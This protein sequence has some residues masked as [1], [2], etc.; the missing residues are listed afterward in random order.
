VNYPTALLGISDFPDTDSSVSAC[1]AYN[2][3]FSATYQ[4]A[5]HDRLLA[6]ALV[7]LTNVEAAVGEATRAVNELGAVGIM[8]QPYADGAHLCD[9]QYDA[10]W[11]VVQS[12]DVPVGIH[13]SRHTCPPH[14]RGESFRSQSRFYA[15]SHPFQ[16]QV[17]MG[18]LVLGGVFDRFPNLKVVFLESGVGWMPHYIDRLDEAYRSVDEDGARVELA[19]KPSDYLLSGNCWFSCESDEPNLSATVDF[20]GDSQVIY[21]S[22]YPHFD[23]SF[24]DSVKDLIEESGL[25]TARI[26]KIAGANSRALYKL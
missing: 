10:L 11:R 14:L 3:W 22:D 23:C 17:A 18:D 5:A 1:H 4:K 15:M 21:A 24:P 25:T 16:Q 2:D 13:G 8:V 12:L 6:M 20:L 7:P 9:P 26:E 19:N